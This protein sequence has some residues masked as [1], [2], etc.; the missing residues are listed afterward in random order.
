MDAPNL[1]KIKEISG[2]MTDFEQEML[3]I[4]KEELPE[5]IRQYRSDLEAKDFL[6]TAG[7]VHKLKHKISI[8]NMKHGYKTAVAYENE[9]RAGRPT[10]A[11]DFEAVLNKMVVFVNQL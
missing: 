3:Q 5:E 4:I 11:Q 6:K 8:L 9:L 1:L 2:G 10:S 7:D